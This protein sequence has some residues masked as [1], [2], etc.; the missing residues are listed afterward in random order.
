MYTFKNA[1]H[2][3]NDLNVI[4]NTAK[5]LSFR[6]V[7][8]CIFNI[9]RFLCKFRQKFISLTMHYELYTLPKKKLYH[10]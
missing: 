3:K 4:V 10:Q 6:Y 2:I 5:F 8:Y 9:N 7:N 1:L